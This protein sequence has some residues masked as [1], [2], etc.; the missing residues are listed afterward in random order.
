MKQGKSVR[1]SV[2]KGLIH[3]FIAALPL[4]TDKGIVELQHISVIGSILIAVLLKSHSLFCQ[5]KRVVFQGVCLH[6]PR[7]KSRPPTTAP[8]FHQR[9]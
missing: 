7:T 8:D 3:S 6:L 4:Y 2:S 5:G 9:Q 1:L